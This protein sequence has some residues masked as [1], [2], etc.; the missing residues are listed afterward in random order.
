MMSGDQVIEPTYES[1]VIKSVTITKPVDL[2]PENI[3]K[4]TSIGGVSGMFENLI[5]Q[6]IVVS[7]A[8][9]MDNI[10]QNATSY[11]VGYIY[12]YV[13]ESTPA[14]EKDSIYMLEAVSDYV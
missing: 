3:R 14:Y 8:E 13:G 4:G 11:N 7:K 9:E 10:L 5:G 12:K 2:V 6:P 1:S